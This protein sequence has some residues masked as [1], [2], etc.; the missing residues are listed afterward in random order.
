MNFSNILN[1]KVRLAVL[2]VFICNNDKHFKSAAI[3]RGLKL[4]RPGRKNQPGLVSPTSDF[5]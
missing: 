3:S 1:S 5:I 4:R 2:K